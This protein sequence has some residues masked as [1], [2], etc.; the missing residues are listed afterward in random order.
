M[1]NL[2]RLSDQQL[3]QIL[4]RAKAGDNQV[5]QSL[6]LYSPIPLLSE[7]MRRN[8][9]RQAQAAQS[10]PAQQP[11]VAD[12]IAGVGSLPV[13]GVMREENFADGGIVAFAK[14]STVPSQEALDSRL[15]GIRQ[16]MKEDLDKEIEDLREAHGPA[17]TQ[18][19]PEER[20]AYG[21]KAYEQAQ[22]FDRPYRE[23]LESMTAQQAP[24]VEGRKKDEF[25]KA[26]L[27]ASLALMGGRGKGFSGF[28]SDV[29]G[30]ARVGVQGYEAGMDAVRRA[31]E[32]HKKSLLLTEKYK[33]E[34]SKGNKKLADEAMDASNVA[35]QN[36]TRLY[37]AGLTDIAK[38]RAAGMQNIGSTV[39]SLERTERD[40]LRAESEARKL[41]LQADKLNAM[42]AGI[43]GGGRG[44]GGGGGGGKEDLAMRREMRQQMVRIINTKDHPVR[45]GLQQSIKN[46]PGF[47]SLSASQKR[48]ALGPGL[49]QVLP[50]Y[51]AKYVEQSF[52]LEPYPRAAESR[53]RVAGPASSAPPPGANRV[54]NFNDLLK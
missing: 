22:E 54:Y 29:G 45:I 50:E 15:L 42:M 38:A 36:S 40:R 53:A 9:M 30:A 43:L 32:E 8:S 28:V 31:E 35:E 41:D 33:Y 47:S 25:N 11:T 44:G 7:K 21:S 10:A 18:M 46:D 34:M 24:D 1:F 52:G 48:Y 6:G 4:Q 26:M 39:S 27:N 5:L 3:D 13:P 14:G 51:A 17:P 12:K 23:K 19:T 20:L 2:N 37:R 49:E 16:T